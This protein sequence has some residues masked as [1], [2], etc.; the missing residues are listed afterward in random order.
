MTASAPATKRNSNAGR[1]ILVVT[2]SAVG[3]FALFDWA[4]G[5]WAASRVAQS[6]LVYPRIGVMGPFATIA[7]LSGL[8]VGGL[9]AAFL[10]GRSVR[11]AVLAAVVACAMSFGAAVVAGGLTWALGEPTV[12]LGPF[13]GAG[14]VCGAWLIR[15]A[16]H[17]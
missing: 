11:V 3:A 9:V 17:A 12:L 1:D 8:L 5:H 6:W 2:A 13:L 15:K 7:I 14:L 10:P 16:R 4:F